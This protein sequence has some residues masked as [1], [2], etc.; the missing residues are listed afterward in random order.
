MNEDG[1]C[2]SEADRDRTGEEKEK[3][4]VEREM[5]R[6]GMFDSKKQK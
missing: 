5:T 4:K 2:T 1:D 6:Y 3:G